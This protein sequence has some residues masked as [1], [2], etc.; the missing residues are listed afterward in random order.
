MRTLPRFLKG[1]GLGLDTFAIEEL[2]DVFRKNPI[3]IVFGVT[4][5]ENGLVDTCR[6]CTL[7]VWRRLS[8]Q[9]PATRISATGAMRLDSNV[10][11]V[12][13]RL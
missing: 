8:R 3:V 2:S 1:N 13:T 10:N 6:H 11:R 7:L 12:S 4:N 9:A 5:V